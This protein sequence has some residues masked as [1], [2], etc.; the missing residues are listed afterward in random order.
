MASDR[1]SRIALLALPCL[2][3]GCAGFYDEIFLN[4]DGSGSYRLTVFVKKG[5]G[6][7]ELPA[8]RATVRERAAKIAATAGFT[9]KSVDV[10]RDGPLLVVEATADFPSLTVFANPALCVS[11][12]AGRWSFVVPR[13]AG[14]RDGRFVAHVLRGSAPPRDH[15]LRA[16][17]KGHE[18]RFTVHLPGEVVGGNGQ[19]MQNSANWSFPLEQLC[20]APIQMIALARPSFPVWPV[21]LGALLVAG[22]AV[23]A[24][25]VFRRHPAA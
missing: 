6:D 25:G 15:A 11:E 9:L 1:P 18:A 22:L 4:A 20:D 13:E 7:D 3:A 17:L 10:K 2:L 8:L 16:A 24:R 5:G 12:D 21:V 14:Y 19:P 23:L